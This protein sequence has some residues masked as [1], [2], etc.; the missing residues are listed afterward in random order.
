[1][2]GLNKT[3]LWKQKGKNIE[4]TIPVIEYE[5]VPCDY[6]WTLKMENVK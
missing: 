3:L 2:L 5:E 1:M 4:V 6:A